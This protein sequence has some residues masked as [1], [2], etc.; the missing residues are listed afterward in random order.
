[1]SILASVEHV[2][3]AAISDAKKAAKVIQA[4]VLPALVTIHADA[5]TTE[6]IDSRMSIWNA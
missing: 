5:P 4:Q 3:A 1:M 6:A 2:I